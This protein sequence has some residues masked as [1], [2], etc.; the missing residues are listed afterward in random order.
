MNQ[1]VVS[2]GLDAADPDLLDRWLAAGELPNLARLRA[3]GAYCRFENTADYES[4]AAPFSSTEGSWV[5]LQAGVK[6]D[7]T[8]YWETVAYDARNYV[9]Q[10]DPVNGGYD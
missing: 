1:R 2:I 3:A 6:P 9:A 7:K 5:A 4:E 10:N 8:G